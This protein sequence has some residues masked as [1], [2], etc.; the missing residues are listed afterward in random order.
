MLSKVLQQ[1][2]TTSEV[3]RLYP[4]NPS[5]IRPVPASQPGDIEVSDQVRRFATRYARGVTRLQRLHLRSRVGKTS[6]VHRMVQLYVYIFD[7]YIYYIFRVAL[8][9]ARVEP[10][11]N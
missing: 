5:L 8:C 3:V 4:C 11:Q 10:Y 6:N 9:H 7:T 1:Y 2:K